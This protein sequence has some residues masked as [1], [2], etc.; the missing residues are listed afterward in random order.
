[1]IWEPYKCKPHD[2]LKC[3]ILDITASDFP[4]NKESQTAA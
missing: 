1:M 4:Q 3:A 2:Y